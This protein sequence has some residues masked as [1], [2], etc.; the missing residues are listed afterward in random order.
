MLVAGTFNLAEGKWITLSKGI[1]LRGAVLG[2][3]II[4]V[5]NGAVMS[6]AIG[7]WPE[8]PDA[9]LRRQSLW[10]RRDGPKNGQ[11]RRR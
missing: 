4:N 7:A 1:T 11:R 3:T 6:S 10:D 9:P 5:P 2:S 8:P